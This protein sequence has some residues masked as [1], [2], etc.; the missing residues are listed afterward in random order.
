MMQDP[1]NFS[2]LGFLKDPKSFKM[3]TLLKKRREEEEA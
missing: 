3:T 1:Q 2:N